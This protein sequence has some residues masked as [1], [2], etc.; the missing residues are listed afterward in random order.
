SGALLD[1]TERLTR[2]GIATIPEGVYRFEDRFD[3]DEIADEKLFAT[4]IEVRDGEI[5]L[6]FQSPPQVRAGLNLVWTGL[7]ATVYY[8]VKT[9]VGPDIPANAG[10]FRPI[11]VSGPRRQMLKCTETAHAT[12]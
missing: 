10:L 11:H 1:Y 2:A 4:R 7:L 6:H 12:S 3:T 8:A 9:L 5:F